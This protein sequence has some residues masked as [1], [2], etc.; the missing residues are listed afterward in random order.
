MTVDEDKLRKLL[1]L[2][3]NNPSASEANAAVGR[4]LALLGG[5]PKVQSRERVKWSSSG[6]RGP[7]ADNVRT[8]EASKQTIDDFLRW[9]HQN[10][11]GENPRREQSHT[12][13][14]DKAKAAYEGGRVH[15]D[16]KNWQAKYQPGHTHGSPPKSGTPPKERKVWQQ[17][18]D[19]SVTAW[20]ST[21]TIR[22][23]SRYHQFT[24]TV[25][26]EGAGGINGW[27]EDPLGRKIAFASELVTM[28]QTR[29]EALAKVRR[30]LVTWMHEH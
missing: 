21:D 4:A 28:T 25:I 29:P 13:W 1:M 7:S 17:E 24:A 30:T 9:F 12:S 15:Y 3:H 23:T 10:Y 14:N 2:A 11:G 16:A 8:D 22:W 6:F 20:H 18:G 27:V 5:P 19:G 26:D